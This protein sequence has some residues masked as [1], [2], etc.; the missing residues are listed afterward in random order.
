MAFKTNSIRLKEYADSSGDPASYDGTATNGDLAIVGSTLKL[1]TGGNWVAIGGGGGGSLNNVVEDTTPELGGDL[2]TDGNKIAHAAGGSVSE[3][4]FTHTWNGETNHTHLASV[5]SIDLYLDMNQ[6]DSDQAIRVYNDIDPNTGAPDDTNYIWKLHQ[7]GVMYMKNDINMGTNVITDAKV[8]NWDATYTEVNAKTNDWDAAYTWGNHA[9]A[10]Y[11]TSETSHADVVVDG[12]FASEGLMR[13]GSADG[14][15]SV[16]TDNSANWDQAWGWG[17][18]NTQGYVTNHTQINNNLSN[19]VTIGDVVMNQKYVVTGTPGG[20][21]YM[22]TGPAT[23]YED[24]Q[25]IE[26]INMS[27]N[28]HAVST[29]GSHSF[30]HTNTTSTGTADIAIGPGQ[31]ALI[32]PKPANNMFFISILTA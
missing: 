3:L 13:R 27:S 7:S 29:G 31:R 10:G 11:L 18:H 1:R 28:S 4:T 17:N 20:F 5:K 6:G 25:I 32:F 23:D 22:F 21:K 9:S 30:Y 14:V 2:I 12:D 16:I 24:N 19:N 8:A 15:Y 26:I